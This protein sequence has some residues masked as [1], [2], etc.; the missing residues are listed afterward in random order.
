M[1]DAW[2]LDTDLGKAASNLWGLIFPGRQEPRPGEGSELSRDGGQNTEL[3]G[4]G[5]TG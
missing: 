5:G 4:G 2:A 1:S 3:G